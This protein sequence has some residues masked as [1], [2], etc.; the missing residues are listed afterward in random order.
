MRVEVELSPVVATNDMLELAKLVDE[1]GADRLGISDVAM[2]RDTFL[3][4]ALCVQATDRVQIGSLVSN[5]YLRHPV[6]VATTLATLNEISQGRA[7][8]GIGV[9]AGLSGLGIDQSRPARRLEEFLLV[10]GRLLSGEKLDWDGPAHRI[11]GAQIARDIACQ[12]P[13]VVGTRSRQ[14]AMLAGSM[15]DAVVVGAR[16]MRADIL[17]RYRGWVHQGAQAAGRD[18][19]E[20]EV[21]PRVTL[22]VSQDGEIARRTVTLYAA[23]YLSL[24]SVEQSGLEPERF[25]RIRRLAGEATGWY[26]EPEVPLQGGVGPADHLRPD[27]A[28]RCCGHPEGMPGPG[29]ADR[30]H[31]VRQHQHERGR[32]APVRW[33]HVLGY[34]GDH[35]RARRDDERNPMYVE[36]G[37]CSLRRALR[38][39]CEDDS[40]DGGVSP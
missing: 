17:D 26:F 28:V 9:G 2:L 29:A 21:A 39:G 22:C 1:A 6:A 16:E 15:A 34:A 13:V 27:R 38:R 19:A 25:R 10:V 35:R 11:R 37:R 40:D 23:H 8:L 20:V 3:V 24:G 5:P 31:G 30:R 18:P 4:Q 12:V 14:V 32:R 36:P 33:V 7:F